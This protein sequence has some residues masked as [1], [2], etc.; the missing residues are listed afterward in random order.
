MEQIVRPIPADVPVAPPL[1]RVAAYARV[2][3]FR[4]MQLESLAAQVSHYSGLIQN[5]PGW[6]YAGVFCV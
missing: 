2:S 5:H 1:L 6:A 3:G 4:E